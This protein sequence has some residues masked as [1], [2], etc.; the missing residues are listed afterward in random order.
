MWVSVQ[1][2]DP[3][4]RYFTE[5][6]MTLASSYICYTILLV[7]QWVSDIQS[8]GSQS[9]GSVCMSKFLLFAP[10]SHFLSSVQVIQCFSSSASSF[11]PLSIPVSAALNAPILEDISIAFGYCLAI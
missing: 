5:S 7:Y 1:H 3:L 8:Q 2:F 11:A 10:L 9:L 4:V 6:A